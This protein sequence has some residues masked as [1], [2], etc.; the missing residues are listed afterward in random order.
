MYILNVL[1][2]RF[3]GSCIGYIFIGINLKN[4]FIFFDFYIEKDAI[5]RV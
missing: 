3:I 5:D 4:L 2:N 1:M